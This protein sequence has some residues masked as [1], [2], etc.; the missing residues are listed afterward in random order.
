[1]MNQSILTV[2]KSYKT[3][4]IIIGSLVLLY[5]II[6][7]ATRKSQIPVDLK[8]SIDSLTVVNKKL[9][10]SQKHMDST[11]SIYESKIDQ[12][13]TQI[14]NIKNKTII[15]KEYHH[16]IIERTN[17]YSAG[18]IDSFFKSRYNY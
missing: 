4:L 16:D 6:L 9:I 8:A 7:L 13:D 1:M 17:H 2:K 14:S 10:E 18:Q 3:I 11:I 15:I 5:G 12:I